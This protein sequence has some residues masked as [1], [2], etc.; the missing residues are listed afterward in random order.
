[1]VCPECG[2]PQPG[3][4]RGTCSHSAMRGG[5]G[6]VLRGA[7]GSTTR[8]GLTNAERA[9]RYAV[10]RAEAER[11]AFERAVR[12]LL[13]E[14]GDKFER[15]EEAEE[16]VRVLFARAEY[17]A[18]IERVIDRAEREAR[19]GET[20]IDIGRMGPLLDQAHSCLA[21]LAYASGAVAACPESAQRL[22]VHEAMRD[23][24]HTLAHMEEVL[25]YGN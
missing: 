14:H 6:S 21:K 7:W 5:E 3:P 17:P 25:G 8:E 11:G 24:T 16:V 4:H 15:D 10:Q 1:M 9:T 22:T 23:L 2:L 20:R 18:E 12:W 19:I 13:D